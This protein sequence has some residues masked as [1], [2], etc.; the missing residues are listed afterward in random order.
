MCPNTLG[1]YGTLLTCSLPDTVSTLNS[2]PHFWKKFHT[3]LPV[4]LALVA[5]SDVRLTGD[6]VGSIHAGSGNIL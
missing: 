6:Q 2:I 4:E 3:S 5:Q 1:K